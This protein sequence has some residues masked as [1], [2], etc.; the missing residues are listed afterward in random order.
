MR[1]S[2]G[3]HD[4]PKQEGRQLQA[5]SHWKLSSKG[6]HRP[7]SEPTSTHLA[8][9]LL[10]PR[11]ELCKA[12][13]DCAFAAGPGA[14][15]GTCCLYHDSDA[16]NRREGRRSAKVSKLHAHTEARTD[17]SPEKHHQSTEKDATC[18][19]GASCQVPGAAAQARAGPMGVTQRR[20]LHLRTPSI[21]HQLLGDA[22]RRTGLTNDASNS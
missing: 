12:S 15:G 8:R 11:P 9:E 14:A 2:S 6:G 21:E 5:S 20:A 4:E 18:H 10:L 16:S 7:S 1:E 13:D 17:K 19:Q 3:T 22:G